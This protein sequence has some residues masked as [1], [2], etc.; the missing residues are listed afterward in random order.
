MNIKI[1]LQNYGLWVAIAAF[2][3]LA[4]EVAGVKFDL[5][6]FNVV[7]NSFLGLLVLLGV[8]SNPTTENKGF[9]DDKPAQTEIINNIPVK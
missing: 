5:G 6:K 9:A 7:V 2:I 1:R 4:L 8:I 3:A